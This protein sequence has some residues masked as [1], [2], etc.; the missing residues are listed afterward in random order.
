MNLQK[1][2][3][4]MRKFTTAIAPTKTVTF[5]RGYE[6]GYRNAI[7]QSLEEVGVVADKIREMKEEYE[8]DVGT[9]LDVGANVAI[10][11][12]NII[13]GLLVEKEG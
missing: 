7:D 9:E 6:S 13:L 3:E 10:H 1:K 2:L 8:K 12:L 4:K 11:V 5:S